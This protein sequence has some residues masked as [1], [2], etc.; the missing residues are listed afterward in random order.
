MNHLGDSPVLVIPPKLDGAFP[1]VREC[2]PSNS[3]HNVNGLR[4]FLRAVRSDWQGSPATE[5]GSSLEKFRTRT[6]LACVSLKVLCWSLVFFSQ[7]QIAGASEP[8][9]VTGH[10]RFRHFEDDRPKNYNFSV[11]VD[12]CRWRIRDTN[13]VVDVFD[14]QEVSWDGDQL[15][16]LVSQRS[17]IERA[18]KSV[19]HDSQKVTNVGLA[20]V[21]QTEILH[22]LTSHEIGPIWLM[23]ASS[24]YFGKRDTGDLIEPVVCFGLGP[25]GPY[26]F[27]KHPFR[28][29]AHWRLSPS[30]PFLPEEV[31]FLDDGVLRHPGRAV[32]LGRRAT[33][34]ANGFTNAIYSV[35]EKTN[36]GSI[37]LPSRSCLKINSVNESGQLWVL[38]EYIITVD[39]VS[40]A[41]VLETFIPTMEGRTLVTDSRFPE[42]GL[43]TYEVT[44]REWTSKAVVQQS[45]VYREQLQYVDSQRGET[46]T[47]SRS[48]KR[49]TILAMFC[50]LGALPIV[51]LALLRSH[52]KKNRPAYNEGK[53]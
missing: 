11:L 39:S 18:N 35:V 38:A 28:Q 6:F 48:R 31:C 27:W 25:G 8:Y 47:Q 51:C 13:A 45:K 14:F 26:S 21:S 37:I 19:N 7:G 10:V 2:R 41:P 9:E 52:S 12:G 24:C 30:L 40:I 17:Q 3:S 36:V 1:R 22:D 42:L 46:P 49:V 23:L 15:Y 44:N 5:V 43:W 20:L 16:H 34:F 33:P 32:D 53:P 29:V 4:E 50:A